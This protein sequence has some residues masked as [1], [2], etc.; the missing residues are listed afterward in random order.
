MKKLLAYKT[1]EQIEDVL[2]RGDE[3]CAKYLETIEN[4]VK[5]IVLFPFRVEVKIIKIRLTLT[6]KYLEGKAKTCEAILKKL[7]Y[8]RKKVAKEQIEARKMLKDLRSKY[9]Y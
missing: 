9:N 4:A 3:K 2:K 8:E 5:A 6:D 1:I 7:S